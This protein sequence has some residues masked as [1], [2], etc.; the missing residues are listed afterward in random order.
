M[1]IEY[2]PNTGPKNESTLKV[3]DFCDYFE[4]SDSRKQTLKVHVIVLST[5]FFCTVVGIHSATGK[6]AFAFDSVV[7]RADL[8]QGS[9]SET[10]KIII[11]TINAKY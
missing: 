10:T 9:Y 5:L 11:C 2:L 1:I 6:V 3:W 8:L 4:S 7:L